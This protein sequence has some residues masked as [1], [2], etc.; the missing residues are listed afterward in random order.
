MYA[1]RTSRN[2]IS[3]GSCLDGG[4][5]TLALGDACCCCW[6]TGGAATGRPGVCGLLNGAGLATGRG[7]SD[8]WR[9]G[10]PV[11]GAG[12]GVG[13]AGR[14]VGAT[15]AGPGGGAVADADA[16]AGVC[17]SGGCEPCND[18][19]S[20]CGVG[21]IANSVGAG[22]GLGGFGAAIFAS[23]FFRISIRISV[24]FMRLA[25]SFRS[26]GL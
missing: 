13:A 22:A 6:L 21:F 11:G 24:C 14:G 7:G 9:E 4:T 16:D 8:G 26:P 1:Q 5:I 23:C 25:K 15:V 19:D 10:V 2:F 12:A 17:E 18:T 3:G 20:C